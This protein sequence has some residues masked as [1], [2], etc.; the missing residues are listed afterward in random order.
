MPASKAI[1]AGS[2]KCECA[3]GACGSVTTSRTRP[4]AVRPTPHH[5]RPSDL[6]AEDAL[7]Q[8]GE[9]HDAGGEHGLDDRQRRERHRRDVQD[10]GPDRDGHADREPLL[11]EQRPDAEPRPADVDLRGL[12]GAAVLVQEAEL[13]DEGAAEREKDSEVERHE[14]VR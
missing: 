4:S 7:G 1:I 11:R 2:E 6:E 10:P 5:W 9:H 14:G 13:R 12:T 3:P 8:H